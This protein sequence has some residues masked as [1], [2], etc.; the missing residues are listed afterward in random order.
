MWDGA[1]SATE[2]AE[3]IELFESSPS[4]YFD[5]NLLSY[6]KS[7]V[8]YTYKK[9]RRETRGLLLQEAALTLLLN[10]GNGA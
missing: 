4:L 6:G 1:L 5:G 9:V 10:A 3:L 8:D 7:I 2:C